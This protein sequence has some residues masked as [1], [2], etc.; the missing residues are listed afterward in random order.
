MA[1]ITPLLSVLPELLKPG[2]RF[3][4]SVTHPVFNS[5]DESYRGTVHK[6]IKSTRNSRSRSLT[7]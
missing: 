2:G 5:G 3:V 6:G 1:S 7:T 4:F